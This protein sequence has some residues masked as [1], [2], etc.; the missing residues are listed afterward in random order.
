MQRKER[1]CWLSTKYALYCS[2][3]LVLY[4]SNKTESLI[5][6]IYK[7]VPSRDISWMLSNTLSGSSLVVAIF[8][9]LLRRNL[10]TTFYISDKFKVPF[11]FGYLYIKTELYVKVSSRTT[12]TDVSNYPDPSWGVKGYRWV[13]MGVTLK[14]TTSER[15][16]RTFQRSFAWGGLQREEEMPWE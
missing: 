2:T 7:G 14:S 8:I 6:N 15:V 1:V 12:L 16:G 10:T 4:R 9:F 11:P 5:L 3:F 13:W